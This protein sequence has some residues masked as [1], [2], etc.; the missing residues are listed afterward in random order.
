[1]SETTRRII[2]D[3]D[4]GIDDALALLYLAA[5]PEVEFV[6]VTAVYG[7]CITEDSLRNIAYVLG[8]AGRTGIPVARGAAAPL[9]A[10][11]HIAHYVH[12]YDGLGDVL[13]AEAR[14]LPS[15]LV[16][17]SAAEFLVE[18]ARAHPGE[19]ELLTLGPLTNIALA[20]R[21]EPQL[22]TLFRSITIMGGS[23]PFPELGQSDMFDANIQ[24]DADAARLV[25][26][27][28]ATRR[29]MVGVNATAQ[30]V[31]DEQDMVALHRSGTATGVFS[32]D[33]LESYLDF[34][35]LA[36]GRRVSPVHDGLAAGL[37]LH[38]EWIAS[39]VTGPANITDD[40]FTTRARIMQTAEGRTVPWP[41]DAVPDTIAVT[42]IDPA[43]HSAFIH[44]LIGTAPR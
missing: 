16:S 21:V 30:V 37:M 44:A 23:G 1:M 25:F 8:L 35:R 34:Y 3:T 5:Q 36:W 24:N 27:A 4:T 38:P 9:N 13:A 17:Q 19:F 29:V 14:P 31:T 43:F 28:P 7:N 32:A 33:I 18:Q 2:V 41:I 11:P 26:S 39:S 22:L 40:G 42:S 15:T 6:G 12:G 10:E 20:L